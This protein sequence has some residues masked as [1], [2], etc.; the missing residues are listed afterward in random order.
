MLKTDVFA[1]SRFTGEGSITLSGVKIPYHT[2]W[3]YITNGDSTY[4]QF[5]PSE[6][7]FW[8]LQIRRHAFSRYANSKSLS[9]QLPLSK[10]QHV[11]ETPP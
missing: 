4:I 11:P 9:H 2:H 3:H 7:H 1:P 6:T 10:N 5:S 8:H